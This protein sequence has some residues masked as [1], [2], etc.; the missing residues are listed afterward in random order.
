MGFEIVVTRAGTPLLINRL[1][2]AYLG[3]IVRYVFLRGNA[4]NVDH[5]FRTFGF[6]VRPKH[7]VQEFTAETL[8]DA[9]CSGGRFLLASRDE[10]ASA[11]QALVSETS[12]IKGYTCE[13]VSTVL[14][15]LLAEARAPLD[16][17]AHHATVVD[18][19]ARDF[20][21]FPLR[22]LSL[23]YYLT[24]LHVA[25][26]LAKLDELSDPIASVAATEPIIANAREFVA[27]SKPFYL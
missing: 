7:L 10:V 5:A 11:L 24:K 13:I 17:T 14:L 26:V 16:S 18:V 22:Y 8:A 25:E 21:D 20:L 9:L 12:H 6:I 1:F 2:Y 27:H 3:P 4:S 19:V 15:S 23:C